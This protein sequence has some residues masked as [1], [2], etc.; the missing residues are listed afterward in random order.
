MNKDQRHAIIPWMCVGS[1][2][3]VQLSNSISMCDS[4]VNNCGIPTRDEINMLMQY[5]YILNKYIY[6]Y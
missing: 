6:I 1:Y 3:P 4:K 5:K 2:R